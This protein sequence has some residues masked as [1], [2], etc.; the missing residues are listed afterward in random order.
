MGKMNF[1]LIVGSRRLV[2]EALLCLME[3]HSFGIAGAVG[4]VLD[5]KDGAI[6]DTPKITILV[7]YSV[8]DAASEVSAIRRL[9]P[10]TKIILLVE[11]AS[12]AYFEMLASQ[13]DACMP[14]GISPDAF[15]MTVQRVQ[16]TGFRILFIESSVGTPAPATA[17]VAP[18]T[19][20]GELTATRPDANVGSTLHQLS[21][22]EQQILRDLARGHSNKI[23]ARTYSL[24]E[25]T[26]KVHMKSIL[27]KTRLANR[28]QA[29]IWAMENGYVSAEK[30]AA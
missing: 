22:R 19:E 21:D 30:D 11:E 20:P 8:A 9:W 14:L 27:R 2:R 12:P 29:A 4:S 24:A 13:I 3:R 17:H 23:I 25:A 15:L 16:E 7:A 10:G 5:I 18:K 28:T 1:T 26:V 6:V